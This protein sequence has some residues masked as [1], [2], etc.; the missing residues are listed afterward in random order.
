MSSRDN[1]RRE[2]GV[3]EH[4]FFFKEFCCKIKKR[5]AVAARGEVTSTE[6]LGLLFFFCF[7]SLWLGA[8]TTCSLTD[9]RSSRE[10]ND[11]A[12]NRRKKSLSNILE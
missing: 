8:A 2:T 6:G 10:G 12:G 9:I 11:V 7:F 3:R 5:N 4:K 1:E